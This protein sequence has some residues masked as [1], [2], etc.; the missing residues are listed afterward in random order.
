MERRR[1]GH[2]SVIEL[3]PLRKSVCEICGPTL[4]ANPMKSSVNTKLKLHNPTLLSQCS[5]LVGAV[6]S[7]HR[8]LIEEFARL[9]PQRQSLEF[10]LYKMYYQKHVNIGEPSCIRRRKETLHTS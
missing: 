1:R 3:P 2:S 8:H 5:P 4:N 7:I 9:P 10:A 6:L